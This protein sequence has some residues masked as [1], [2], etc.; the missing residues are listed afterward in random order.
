LRNRLVQIEMRTAP[1]KEFISNF[2]KNEVSYI[3]CKHPDFLGAKKSAISK[4]TGDSEV[5]NLKIIN[6]ISRSTDLKNENAQ[7]SSS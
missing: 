6:Y 7:L 1:A 2:I 4:M 3:N 5:R